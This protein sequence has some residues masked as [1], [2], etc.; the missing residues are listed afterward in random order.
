[1]MVLVG[2]ANR[3]PDVFDQPDVIDVR[4][5]PNPHLGFMIGIHFC[6]GAPLARLETRIVVEEVLAR[7]PGYELLNPKIDRTFTNK[8]VMRG[9]RALP[10]V[11]RPETMP[12]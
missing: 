2:S 9:V 3:D 4:R 1:M 5:A 12:T 10:V 7:F 6:V 8:A 11:L